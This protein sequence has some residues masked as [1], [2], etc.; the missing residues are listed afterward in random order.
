MSSACIPISCRLSP[1][2]YVWAAIAW[3]GVSYGHFGA[4][5]TVVLLRTCG[6]VFAGDLYYRPRPSALHASN[7]I[8]QRH[9]CN[10]P[11]PRSEPAA[12]SAHTAPFYVHVGAPLRS[13]DIARSFGVHHH[14]RRCIH[15]RPRPCTPRT[16]STSRT[17][18]P[19]TTRSRRSPPSPPPARART[20]RTGTRPG[21]T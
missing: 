17:S 20:P 3:F 2:A 1:A 5:P 14:R 18:P 16:R 7:S 19:S 15:P 8:I 13:E 9:A 4:H 10:D 21:R 6:L 12:H 11:T